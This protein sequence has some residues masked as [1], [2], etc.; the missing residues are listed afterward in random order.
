M[1]NTAVDEPQADQALAEF[2]RERD[3]AC[4][5]CGYNLRGL[6][7]G[8]CP[9]CGHGLR[10]SVGLTEPYLR[11]WVA[12]LVASCACAGLGVLFVWVIVREGFPPRDEPALWVATVYDVMAVPQAIALLRWRRRFLRLPRSVQRS[13]AA[14]CVAGACLAF[15]MILVWVR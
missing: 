12:A 10:L 4:P 2:V 11:S 3:V 15:L 5:L 1:S 13:L 7:S 8:R 6:T 9:E 14:L